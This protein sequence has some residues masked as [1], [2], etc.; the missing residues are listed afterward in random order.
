[1]IALLASRPRRR[2]GSWCSVP[3]MRKARLLALLGSTSVAAVLA[4]VSEARAAGDDWGIHSGDTLGRTH[5]ALYFEGGWP[6][7]TLGAHYGLGERVDVGG[8]FAFTY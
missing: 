5:M 4:Y 7:V 3:E 6:G 8:R 2:I 1:M